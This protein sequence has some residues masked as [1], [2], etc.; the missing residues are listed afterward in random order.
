MGSKMSIELIL[1]PHSESVRAELA[2]A[3]AWGEYVAELRSILGIV[4]ENSC[5]DLLEVGE[6]LVNQP[7]TGGYLSL[8]NGVDISSREAIDLIERMV[9]GV[10]PYCRLSRPGRLRIESGWDGAVHLYVKPEV[11]ADMMELHSRNVSLQRRNAYL[12]PAHVSKIVDS[13]AD[14]NF[15][16][17]VQ[18]ISGRATLLCERWAHGAYGC[19][20][21]WVT[22]GM[23]WKWL[24]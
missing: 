11:A 6:L 2:E 19:R 18:D 8:R 16:N 9:A 14:E 5:V 24:D 7:L 15:W 4:I 1:S 12:E 21:F 22:G 23:R 17:A 10:G 20:W 13:V 3:R